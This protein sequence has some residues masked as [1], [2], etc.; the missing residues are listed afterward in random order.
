MPPAPHRGRSWNRPAQFSPNTTPDDPLGWRD[1]R[2]HN[3][4]PCLIEGPWDAPVDWSDTPDGSD[5]FFLLG[6][7]RS[8]TSVLSAMVSEHPEVYCGCEDHTVLSVLGLLCTRWLRTQACDAI[9]Y[10]W[11]RREPWSG[12]QLRCFAE[13]YRQAVEL[14]TGR[15]IRLIGDKSPH[16]LQR[17]DTFRRLFP[18]CR[19]IYTARHPLDQLASLLNLPPGQSTLQWQGDPHGARRLWEFVDLL[20]EQ[21]MLMTDA[22]DVLVLR[23]EDLFAETTMLAAMARAFT[24]IG[25]DISEAGGA[26]PMPEDLRERLSPYAQ[27]RSPVGRWRHDERVKDLVGAWIASG[28]VP[29]EKLSAVVC[30]PELYARRMLD[31]WRAVENRQVSR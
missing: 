28:T 31:A 12:R 3:L 22:P 30:A 4:Q 9:S 2:Q 6:Y 18:N 1:F 13:A 7:G 17:I 15:A 11:H 24:H 29:A 27:A 14:Q 8:G 25:A 19:F 10:D 26:H 23:F 21:L 16:Y 20:G 5:W